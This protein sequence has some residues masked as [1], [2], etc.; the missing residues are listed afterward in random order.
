[1]RKKEEGK[2]VRMGIGE[3]EGEEEG[4]ET[5]GRASERSPIS[6][7]YRIPGREPSPFARSS[8]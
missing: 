2:Q 3:G 6:L 8:C 5:R 7:E 4:E 1:M